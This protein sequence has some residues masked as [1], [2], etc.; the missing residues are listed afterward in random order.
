[1][2]VYGCEYED[3]DEEN[4]EYQIWSTYSTNFMLCLLS[5]M[6]GR[7]LGKRI[8]CCHAAGKIITT[9]YRR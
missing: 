9:R 8:T 7:A 3:E 2:Q 5:F 1:M 4:V 6:Q